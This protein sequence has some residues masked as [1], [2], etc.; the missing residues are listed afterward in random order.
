MHHLTIFAENFKMQIT[1]KEPD[2]QTIKNINLPLIQKHKLQN[3]IEVFILKTPVKEISSVNFLY[4]KGVWNQKH[5]LEA[6]STVKL[7][8]RG[9][10]SNNSKQIADFYDFH[11]IRF[12]AEVGM[13]N[14]VFKNVMLNKYL[15]KA[16]LMQ[17]EILTE[18]K[19][20]KKEFDLYTNNQKE[21]FIIE[22]EEAENI[23]RYEF[24]EQ[25]YGAKHPYGSHALPDDFDK[26]KIEWLHDFY[27]QNIA[28][29]NL[30]I[31]AITYD[32]ENLLKTLNKIF[33]DFRKQ[34]EIKDIQDYP[35]ESGEKYRLIQKEGNLQAAIRT[36]WKLFDKNHPDYIDMI[37]V[38]S[39]FG[40]YY[41]ARLM[42]NIRQR[43]GLTYGIYSILACEKY[44]GSL[45]I[46]AE[47]KSDAKERVF[48]EIEK[49][50]VKLRTELVSQEELDKL[51]R[52]L[53]GSLLRSID[54]EFGYYQRIINFLTYQI[55][56]N[57]YQKL[58]KRLNQITPQ[59][60]QQLA[61][62]YLDPE[63]MYKTIVV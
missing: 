6:N 34:N 36:G 46:I 40:G 32:S 23:A 25:I 12:K 53:A 50:I 4:N 54:G 18:P 59:Q 63:Q 27:Q 39:L 16:M 13:H 15:E 24:E 58:F 1:N 51:R 41:G 33:G 37:I 2:L 44:N 26:L 55:D 5:L 11:S 60:I 31:I 21:K 57:F 47:V 28:S 52:Y 8:N 17:K 19:F 20:D 14:I 62:K 35:V 45:Q 49:E 38:N 30:K 22:L 61:I 9:T 3:G 56:F 42:Q 48:E 10:K 43:L 29:A 7:L